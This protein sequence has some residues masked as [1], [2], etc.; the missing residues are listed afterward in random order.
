MATVNELLDLRVVICRIHL[1][2]AS[3]ARDMETFTARLDCPVAG[4]EPGLTISSTSRVTTLTMT[5]PPFM[6]HTSLV[7]F[8]HVIDRIDSASTISSTS[9]ESSLSSQLQSSNFLL[10]ATA[11]RLTISGMPVSGSLTIFDVDAKH[12]AFLVRLSV[13]MSS[14]E[15]CYRRPALVLLV[16]KN[17]IW[18]SEFGG[19]VM[20]PTTSIDVNGWPELP[21]SVQCEIES[22]ELHNAISKGHN[23]DKSDE[24]A[25]RQ[26]H[27]GTAHEDTAHDEEVGV[28]LLHC[29]THIEDKGQEDESSDSVANKGCNNQNQSREDNQ[30]AIKTHALNLCRNNLRKSVEQTRRAHSFA[31]R[32][33]T[34]SEDNDSPGE[35]VEVLLGQKTNAEEEHD[36]NDSNDTHISELGLKLVASAPQS[37]GSDSDNGHEPL[38]TSKLLLNR[39]NRS[40][41]RTLTWLESDEEK[42]PDEDDRDSANGDNDEKPL[43]PS[44][45]LG[46][47]LNTNEISP[48]CVALPNNVL[49]EINDLSKGLLHLGDVLLENTLC[50]VFERISRF[51]IGSQVGSL[52]FLIEDLV[53]F[54]EN[55]GETGAV[56]LDKRLEFAKRHIEANDAL[57]EHDGG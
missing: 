16:N 29:N 21:P 32:Q 31:Q 5:Y 50:L 12:V 44:R 27:S 30:H 24:T 6:P 46:S 11:S 34:R 45:S 43:K 14:A 7:A 17:G 48:N 15:G 18:M 56:E 53:E 47:T 37:N 1:P 3:L 55:L 36:G 20:P 52:E 42:K 9:S 25:C 38:N 2:N 57:L 22:S 8:A 13:S 33:T 26:T 51:D 39:A 10:T 54:L 19:R 23:H 49:P 40:N 41:C 35:V 28:R 4:P